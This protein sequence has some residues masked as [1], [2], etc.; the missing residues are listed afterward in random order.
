MPRE[1]SNLWKSD[2]LVQCKMLQFCV[3]TN[4]K[5]LHHFELACLKKKRLFG[6]FIMKTLKDERHVVIKAYK[7]PVFEILRDFFVLLY[8]ALFLCTE[9]TDYMIAVPIL[10]HP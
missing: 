1:T 9:S 5:E 10:W 2:G 3:K 6:F 4:M 8:T 7:F